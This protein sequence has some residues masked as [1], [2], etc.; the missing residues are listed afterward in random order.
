MESCLPLSE[1]SPG[2]ALLSH[3]HSWRLSKR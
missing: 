1:S 3:L 2:Q